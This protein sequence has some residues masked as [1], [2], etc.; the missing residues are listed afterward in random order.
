MLRWLMDYRDALAPDQMT[1]ILKT[2]IRQI[3]NRVS[4][5]QLAHD[6][7][8]VLR[9]ST[10]AKKVIAIPETFSAI[11]AFRLLYIHRVSAAPIVDHQGRIVGNLSAS[12]LR[13]IIAT[14]E[15]LEALLKPVF[16]YLE[17]RKSEK[18]VEGWGR[19]GGVHPDQIRYVDENTA[20]G[21]AIRMVIFFFFTLHVE[22][23]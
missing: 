14:R 22:R 10:A 17:T 11:A 20:L 6:P 9:P 7:N 2:Q 19:Y 12:D 5:R 23:T 3:K 21:T 18:G 16:Q 15:S 1:T 13:G 4:L 8:Q